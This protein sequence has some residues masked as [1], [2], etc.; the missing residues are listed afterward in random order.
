MFA[1]AGKRITILLSPKPGLN[2]YTE[3]GISKFLFHADI[4][5]LGAYAKLRKATI[6][7]F[8]SDR[9]SVCPHG[10][11]R[12]PLDGFVRNLIFRLFQNPVEKVHVSVKP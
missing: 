8:M 11:Y 2:Y 3:Y 10:T 6:S 5:L 12:F 1:S 4:S 9:P 7:F